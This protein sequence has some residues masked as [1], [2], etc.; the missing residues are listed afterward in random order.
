VDTLVSDRTDL[1]GFPRDGAES[2]GAMADHVVD[3]YLLPLNR[4]PG[5][6]GWIAAANQVIDL[7]DV[8]LPVDSGFQVAAPPL[9]GRQFFTLRDLLT[10][11]G[12]DEIRRFDQRID[13]ERKEAIEV[14]TPE[15]VI[16][17]DGD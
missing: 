7:V 1:T 14:H 10:L 8:C 13:P 15:G 12:N 16:R 11:S 9:V 5:A 3:S 2:P 4:R 6:G 17:S